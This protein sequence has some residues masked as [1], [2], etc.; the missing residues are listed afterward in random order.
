MELMDFLQLGR[1]WCE[2]VV[3]LLIDML[4][5]FLSWKVDFKALTFDFSVEL[6]GCYRVKPMFKMEQLKT[7]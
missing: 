7:L 6:L 2:H 3:G 5:G 1:A 4:E